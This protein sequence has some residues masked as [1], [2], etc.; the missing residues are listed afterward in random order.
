MR[1]LFVIDALS[2]GGAQRLLIN[3]AKGL[4]TKHQVKIILH[5]SKLDF[6]SSH[7]KNILIKTLVSENSNGF[8]RGVRGLKLPYFYNE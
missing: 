5:N 6:Y 1:I 7:I 2:S 4:K 3:T 8:S